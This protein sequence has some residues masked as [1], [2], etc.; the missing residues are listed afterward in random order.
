LGTPPI[1]G[2]TSECGSSCA[3]A[4]RAK[5]TAI[6]VLSTAAVKE[7]S[8]TESGS[9]AEQRR[10]ETLA[11]RPA[12]GQTRRRLG[13]HP[14]PGPGTAGQSPGSTSRQSTNSRS[15]N[16]FETD[17]HSTITTQANHITGSIRLGNRIVPRS[18]LA[19]PLAFRVLLVRGIGGF[20]LGCPPQRHLSPRKANGTRLGGIQHLPKAGKMLAHQ[21]A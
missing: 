18:R 19:T 13:R 3:T 16:C 15:G 9:Q 12:T 8:S 5:T 20:D 21:S 11:Q 1:A 17:P 14:G 7:R 4:G 10:R 2:I 6:R